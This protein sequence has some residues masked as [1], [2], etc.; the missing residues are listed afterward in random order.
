MDSSS[1]APLSRAVPPCSVRDAF[2]G[3]DASGFHLIR[4]SSQSAGD[5]GVDPRSRAQGSNVYGS[6]Y[7]TVQ[8]WWRWPWRYER[9]CGRGQV[10]MLWSECVNATIV[11]CGR[12]NFLLDSRMHPEGG[13]HLQSAWT[14]TTKQLEASAAGS[15]GHHPKKHTRKM[16]LAKIYWTYF[17]PPPKKKAQVQRKNTDEV[18]PLFPFLCSFVG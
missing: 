5:P 12:D 15:F 3:C 11:V 6:W 2:P 9:V 1:A 7:L 4:W 17:Y 10:P 16:Q 8:C 14:T 13:G 18:P